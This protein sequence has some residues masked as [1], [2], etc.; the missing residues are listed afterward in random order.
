M[1]SDV[2]RPV[3]LKRLLYEEGTYEFQISKL[4]STEPLSLNL[5][6]IVNSC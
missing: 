2:G 4:F 6:N 3:M 1:I 5:R